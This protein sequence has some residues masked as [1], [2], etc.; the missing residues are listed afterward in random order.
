MSGSSMTRRHRAS[1]PSARVAWLIAGAVCCLS[2]LWT[3]RA[4][5]LPLPAGSGPDGNLV[6]NPGFEIA[7]GV[8]PAGWTLEERVAK[9]GDRRLQTERVHSGHYALML[10]P[11]RQNTERLLELA[12]GQGFPAT[13]YRGKKMYVSAWLAAEGGATAVVG[14]FAIDK[15][16]QVLA[17]LRLEE[18]GGGKQLKFH[19]GVLQVPDNKD[20]VYIVFN[21]LVEGTSGKAFFDDVYLG[22][23]MAAGAAPAEAAQP[24]CALGYVRDRREPA[25]VN[26]A[27]WTDSPFVTLDGKRMYFMYTPW[28]FY[29]LL[30]K[31][32][33][34]KRGPLRPGHHA[35]TRSPWDDS[36]LYVST[37]QADGTW[38]AP[39]NLN[40]NDSE[41]DCCA[42]E[43][44]DGKKLY[45]NKPQ[46]PGSRY[47]D[48]YVSVRNP[49][50]RW[51]KGVDI[52]P[53]VNVKGQQSQNPHLSAD[54]KT[55]YF[56]S[57]RPGGYG[58]NDIW[59]STRKA[60][61]SWSQPVNMGPVINSAEEED[62]I[63][64]SPD[65]NVAYFNH[66]P[67]VAIYRSERVS[68]QWTKPV[69]VEFG[70]HTPAR[71][72]EPS[73]TSDGQFM[74]FVSLDDCAQ[75]NVFMYSQRQKDGSWGEA[76]PVD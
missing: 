67:S 74:Y 16:G 41:S 61:G 51:G 36:D 11:N 42:M 15:T 60:D 76:K 69:K 70:A 35:S 20:I 8:L 55:L 46:T 2:L 37:R 3:V 58:K 59:Y 18:S 12:A 47:M 24:A 43:S 29:P 49:D 48:I 53:P 7:A 31:G 22:E 71:V 56:N 73:L 1:R 13:P 33:P 44:A 54:E 26:S 64:V 62:Q 9:K 57:D 66:G 23:K 52:G 72:G 10:A 45:Y 50:G 17:Q 68:G 14:V 21:C 19:E 30:S 65:G 63:W 34:D 5:A 28:N 75:A 27:G 39:V 38:S 32:Q 40:I 6:V 25:K 4:Q